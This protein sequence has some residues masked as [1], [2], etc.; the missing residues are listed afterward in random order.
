MPIFEFRCLKCN[1]VFEMLMLSTDEEMEMRCPHCGSGDFERV[2]S[3]TTYTAGFSRGESRRPSVETRECAS[4]T[5]T[6]W[7][8]PGYSKS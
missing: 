8:V 3:T 4:G 2:L 6:T 7:N 5:C 1:E